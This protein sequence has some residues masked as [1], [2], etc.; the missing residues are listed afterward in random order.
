MT[1]D[2]NSLLEILVCPKCK[3]KL[4]YEENAFYCTAGGCRLKYD[5]RDEIPIMLIDEATELS[6]EEWS[7][8]MQRHGCST[9]IPAQGSSADADSAESNSS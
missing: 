9:E 2:P 3:T 1:F 4:V 6:P 5:V 8:V 7:A